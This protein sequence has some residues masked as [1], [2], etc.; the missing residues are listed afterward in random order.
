MRDSSV[1]VR[2]LAGFADMAIQLAGTG[3]QPTDTARVQRS[4]S[5]HVCAREPNSGGTARKLRLRHCGFSD[6]AKAHPV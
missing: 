4:W 3:L 5:V 1:Q 2:V 6:S